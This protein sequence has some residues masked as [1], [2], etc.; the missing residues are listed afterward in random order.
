MKKLLLGAVAALI[1]PVLVAPAQAARD[2]RNDIVCAMRDTRGNEIGWP[3]GYNDSD[4]FVE[5]GFIKNRATTISP[6]GMRPIWTVRFV[7][8]AVIFGP[9]TILA[10]S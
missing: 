10:I 9:Q 1:A 4:S 7:G 5:T 6:V 8:N 2:Y 3:F